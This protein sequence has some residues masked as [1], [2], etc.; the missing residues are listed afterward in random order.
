MNTVAELV[1]EIVFF[2]LGN[3]RREPLHGRLVSNQEHL[4]VIAERELRGEEVPLIGEPA[5]DVHRGGYEF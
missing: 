3:E 4:A 5:D 2:V 1:D